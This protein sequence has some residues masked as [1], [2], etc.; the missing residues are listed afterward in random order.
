MSKS[1]GLAHTTQFKREKHAQEEVQERAPLA[2]SKVI[3][4]VVLSALIHQQTQPQGV[5]ETIR[6]DLNR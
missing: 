6:T 5:F 3:R 1:G 2:E 4:S